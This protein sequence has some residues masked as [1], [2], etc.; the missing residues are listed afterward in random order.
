[1][2]ASLLLPKSG[3]HDEFGELCPALLHDEEAR[4]VSFVHQLGARPRL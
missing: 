1:M 2:T 4:A 3:Q